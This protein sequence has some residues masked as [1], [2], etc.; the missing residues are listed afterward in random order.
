[1]ERRDKA[2]G[3]LHLGG[4]MVSGRFSEV[5]TLLLPVQAAWGQVTAA[6]A[7]ARWSHC[8]VVVF[9]GTVLPDVI[10]IKKVRNSENFGSNLIFVF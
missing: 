3:A 8:T 5:S 9:A 7:L 10:C 1:M 2:P 6:R 4:S